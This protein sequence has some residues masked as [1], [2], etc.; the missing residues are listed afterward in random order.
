M[1][2]GIGRKRRAE[3]VADPISSVLRPFLSLTFSSFSSLPLA[4]MAS[5][6][7]KFVQLAALESHAEEARHPSL[8]N[9]APAREKEK[10]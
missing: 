2:K 1:G 7:E 9:L 3:S 10:K 4:V 8:A 5:W 6:E